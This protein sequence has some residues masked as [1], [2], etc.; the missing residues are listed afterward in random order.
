MGYDAHRFSARGQQIDKEN[1]FFQFDERCHAELIG[2]LETAHARF[3]LL[4]R[5]RDP[6]GDSDFHS[7][8][9]SKLSEEARR[10]AAETTSETLRGELARFAA[11]LATLS[12]SSD[13]LCFFGD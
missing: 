8:E 3:P 9:I 4:S 2:E 6:Y 5:M 11:A 7:S 12:G 10:L 1:F 13:N